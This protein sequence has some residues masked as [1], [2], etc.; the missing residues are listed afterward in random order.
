MDKCFHGVDKTKTCLWC[1]IILAQAEGRMPVI[2]QSE[3]TA[4]SIMDYLR[5]RLGGT[6]RAEKAKI[7]SQ[8]DALLVAI[9]DG[10]I[11]TGE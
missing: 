9:N 7:E 3:P 5:S 2:H 11:K 8:V 6:T 4:V 10:L 1:S